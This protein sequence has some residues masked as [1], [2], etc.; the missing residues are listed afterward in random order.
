MFFQIVTKS[1]SEREKFLISQFRDT[2]VQSVSVTKLLLFEEQSP[3]AQL[4]ALLAWEQE[5]AGSIPGSA[6]TL[7]E[8]LW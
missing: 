4:V 1:E 7:S 2:T 6:N 3:I 8:D 5:V